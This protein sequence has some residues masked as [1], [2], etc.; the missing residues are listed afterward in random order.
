MSRSNIHTDASTG[1]RTVTVDNLDGTGVRT[2]YLPDGSVDST[3][4]LTG[5]PLPVEP[6]PD[7]VAALTAQVA[8]LTAAL[9]ALLGGT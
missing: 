5:L 8:T 9:N 2:V 7:P 6:T 1:I 4:N 3:E